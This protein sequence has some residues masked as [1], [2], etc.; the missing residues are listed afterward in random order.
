MFKSGPRVNFRLLCEVV[1]KWKWEVKT[2][3]PQP[4]H[5]EHWV[6]AFLRQIVDP[7]DLSAT[8]YRQIVDLY[9]LSAT[10]CRQIVDLYNLSATCCRQILDLCDL[11]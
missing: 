10:C 11:S 4:R 7:Y 6:Y 2:S 8:C 9:D 1:G 5:F 3:H